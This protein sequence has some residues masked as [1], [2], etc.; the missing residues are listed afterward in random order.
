MITERDKTIG[1]KDTKI[2]E[3]EKEIARLN[4]MN[5]SNGQQSSDLQKTLAKTQEELRT[6]MDQIKQLEQRLRDKELEL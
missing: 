2:K 5:A 3:L 6:A 4:D 1:E